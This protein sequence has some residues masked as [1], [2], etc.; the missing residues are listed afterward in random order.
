[1]AQAIAR[2]AVP[3]PRQEIEQSQAGLPKQEG[4]ATAAADAAAAAQAKQAKTKTAAEGGAPV[5][6]AA[7]CTVCRQFSGHPGTLV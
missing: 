4:T 2:L 1:M 6:V 7:N 3:V 5:M